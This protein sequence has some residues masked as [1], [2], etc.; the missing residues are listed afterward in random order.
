VHYVHV[1][2]KH[3]FSGNE[4][5]VP[6]DALRCYHE[7]LSTPPRSVSLDTSLSVVT[8]SWIDS[9]TLGNTADVLGYSG[10]LYCEALLSQRY[11]AIELT[12]SS[13]VLPRGCKNMTDIQRCHV[14]HS[15]Q[16]Y[17]TKVSPD[18]WISPRSIYDWV[19]CSSQRGSCRRGTEVSHQSRHVQTNEG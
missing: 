3:D 9:K 13:Q 16:Q 8:Q 5:P 19:I 15:Q 1:A 4:F 14:Y 7:L 18:P 2:E 17:T 11:P 12:R 6:L 10:D